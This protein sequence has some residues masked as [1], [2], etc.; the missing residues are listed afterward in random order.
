MSTPTEAA[1]AAPRAWGWPV[2]IDGLTYA[3]EPPQFLPTE[4]AAAIAR[5]EAAAP[6]PD[7]FNKGGVHF[8][9]EAFYA[10][11]PRE[12]ST[13]WEVHLGIREGQYMLWI[14]HGD[15]VAELA[16]PATVTGEPDPFADV[17]T[18][19]G[20]IVAEQGIAP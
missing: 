7:R 10:Q 18:L 17:R 13:A 2:T 4:V 14:A 19:I 8:P 12:P 11:L 15:D 16:I 20:R 3:D 9:F 1:Q 5:E 6:A